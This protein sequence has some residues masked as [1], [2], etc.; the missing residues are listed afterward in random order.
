M[1]WLPDLVP[2]NVRA[3]EEIEQ[4]VALFLANGGAIKTYGITQSAPLMTRR[5]MESLSG[6]R[7]NGQAAKRTN[8]ATR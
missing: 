3:R 8:D 5:D 2:G 4:D 7:K 1:I 6:A